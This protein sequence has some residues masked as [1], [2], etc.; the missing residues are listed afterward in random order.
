VPPGPIF[1]ATA[2]FGESE[3]TFPE[4]SILLRYRGLAPAPGT[5]FDADIGFLAP[6]LVVDR[7]APGMRFTVLEGPKPVAEGVVEE[8]R[9]RPG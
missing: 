4:V 5:Q 7:L 3:T 1:A 9:S 2:R 6:E 8:F